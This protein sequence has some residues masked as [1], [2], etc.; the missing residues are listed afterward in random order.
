MN[1]F[2]EIMIETILFEHGRSHIAKYYNNRIISFVSQHVARKTLRNKH[3][4]VAK[5]I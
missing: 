1:I 4:L 5:K 3:F 2:K